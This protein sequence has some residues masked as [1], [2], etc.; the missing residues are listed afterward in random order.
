M[1]DLS[2]LGSKFMQLWI[3]PSQYHIISSPS[4]TLA[5]FYHFLR[6]LLPP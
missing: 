1:W 4:H 3:K 5:A 2:I 6:L